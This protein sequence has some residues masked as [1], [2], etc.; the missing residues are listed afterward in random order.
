MLATCEGYLGLDLTRHLVPG[1]I[2]APQVATSEFD[3]EAS[4]GLSGDNSAENREF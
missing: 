4:Q 3:C 2:H 1:E